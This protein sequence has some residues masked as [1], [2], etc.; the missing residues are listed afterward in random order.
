MPILQTADRSSPRMHV[1]MT[2][3]TSDKPSRRPRYQ[4]KNPQ[5]FHEKYKEHQPD[6]YAADVAQSRG[7]RSDSRGN[8]P[9]DPRCGNHDHPRAATGGT[10]SRLHIGIR[11]TCHRIDCCCAAWRAVD[12]RRLPIPWNCPR[13]KLDCGRVGFPDDSFPWSYDG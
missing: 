10:C 4:G 12:W 8:S 1:F 9:A 6:K 2:E 11:G 5:Q 7:E 13:P 3:P